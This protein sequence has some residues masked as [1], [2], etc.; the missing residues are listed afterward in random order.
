[1]S[2][3]AGVAT[4]TP[5]NPALHS[6]STIYFERAYFIVDDERQMWLCLPPRLAIS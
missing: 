5:E 3:G 6:P 2:T 4:C 1:M